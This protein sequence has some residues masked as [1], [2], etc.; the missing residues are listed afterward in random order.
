MPAMCPYVT[1]AKRGAE[2]SIPCVYNRDW[3]I[4]LG[5]AGPVLLTAKGHRDRRRGKNGVCICQALLTTQRGQSGS[6]LARAARSKMSHVV[7]LIR[8]CCSHRIH[9]G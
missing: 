4:S 2:R 8:A 9:S 1:E 7:A 3:Q 5:A 6:G